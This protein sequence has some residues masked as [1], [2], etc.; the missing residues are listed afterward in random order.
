MYLQYFE[1]SSTSS[2]INT[3]IK[4]NLKIVLAYVFT[5]LYPPCVCTNYTNTYVRT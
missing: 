5:Y 3:K 4:P 2:A 1:M